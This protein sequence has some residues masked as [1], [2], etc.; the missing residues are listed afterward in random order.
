ME[1][2][3]I[4]LTIIDSNPFLDEPI[5]TF[6]RTDIVTRKS[7]RVVAAAVVTL[8]TECHLKKGTSAPFVLTIQWLIG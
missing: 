8:L 6:R 5:S 4:E 7:A 3:N 2:F 1:E